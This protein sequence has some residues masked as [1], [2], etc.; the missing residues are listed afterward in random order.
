MLGGACGLASASGGSAFDCGGLVQGLRSALRIAFE[1][2]ALS[3]AITSSCR[4]MDTRLAIADRVVDGSLVPTKALVVLA[5]R[6]Q[7]TVSAVTVAA[8][9]AEIG[10]SKEFYASCG[11]LSLGSPAPCRC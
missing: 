9:A 6:R 11:N 4:L 5:D 8:Q 1:R 10:D 7:T 2:S 3:L